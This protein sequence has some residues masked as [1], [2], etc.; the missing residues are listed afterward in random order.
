[1]K[2]R[3]DWMQRLT[4]GLDLPSESVPGQPLVEISGEERVLIENHAG[5]TAYGRE[6]ICVKVKFG[7]VQITGCG[8]ELARMTKE[9]LII[10]GRI[11]SVT[12]QRR[13]GR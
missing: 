5:V 3:G 8:L 11:D 1:M 9:Q 2:R 4:E 7:Q 12:L 6:Q 13:S 10:C